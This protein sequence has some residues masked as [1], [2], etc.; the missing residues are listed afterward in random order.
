[1]S[2][3]F[4]DDNKNIFISAQEDQVSISLIMDYEDATILTDKLSFQWR[5]LEEGSGSIGLDFNINPIKN[6]PIGEIIG[7]ENSMYWC[8]S[9]APIY[10]YALEGHFNEDE[11][12]YYLRL[13]LDLNTKQIYHQYVEADYII[14]LINILINEYRQKMIQ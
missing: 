10:Q 2:C 4:I 13:E 8:Y 6:I 1:M 14:S 12:K 7:E 3:N 5:E 9:L 11:H